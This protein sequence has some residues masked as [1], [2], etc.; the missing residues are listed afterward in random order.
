MK[1]VWLMIMSMVAALALF[2]GCKGEEPLDNPGNAE[3]TLTQTLVEVTAEGGHFEVGYTLKNPVDGEKVTINS[4]GKPWLKNIVVKDSV[5]AFDVDESYEKEER[6]SRIELLYPG[7]YPNPTI[8]VKQAIGKEYSIKLDLISATATTITLD[9]IPKDKSM[10]YVFILGN[11][12]YIL[13]NGLME[14]DSA[15]WASDMEIF[16]SFAAA[17]GGNVSNAA[18]AFMYVGELKSH[19]FTGVSANTEYVAYAYGFDTET[20][21]PTTEVSRLL[22]KTADVSEYALDFDFNVEVDGPKVSIDITPQGYDGYYYFGVFWAKDV[23]P[24]TTPER[25]RELCEADWEQNKAQYSSFFDTPEEGLHFIFNELAYTGTTHLDVELDANT[26]FVLWAFGLDGEALLNTVPDTYYFSTG[27]VAK[28]DNVFTLSVA[29]IYPRKATVSIETTNDDSYVAT[30]VTSQRFAN[31]TDDEIVQYIIEKFS[32]QY[33]SGDMNETATGLLPSTEYE[34]LVFGCQVGSATTDLKRLKFTTPEVVYADLD[35]SLSLGNY[36]NGTELAALNPDYAAFSGYAI[37]N[38][39]TNVDSEAVNCYFS[40]MNASE[41]SS[42]TYEQF[43]EGLTADN[44]AEREG[45]YL[46]E[47]DVPYIFF[48]IAE[49]ADGNFTEVWRSKE[50]MFTSEG[51]SPA[52][53]FFESKAEEAPQRKAMSKGGKIVSDRLSLER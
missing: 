6:T 16:E 44:P 39:A 8:T 3:L 2:T 30:L 49:D 38:V 25:L 51:C 42:Y 11:G 32:L 35:F 18:K 20:M 12:K 40:A 15:L 1:N 14:N 41:Y 53:E 47:F 37:V 7:V 43:V 31:K 17:F 28:S 50:I 10:P 46:Y 5:I 13:E 33:A 29:D 36:Y 22:I 27:S 19:T 21:Q 24:G 26:E 34:L 45:S 4:E 48:G 52:E 9:V 23:P